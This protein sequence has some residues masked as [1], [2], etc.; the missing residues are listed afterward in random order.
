MLRVENSGMT[1][2]TERARREDVMVVVCGRPRGGGTQL[3]RGWNSA[4]LGSSAFVL[5][6]C[7]IFA[8]TVSLIALEGLMLRS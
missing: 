4:R 7:C 1:P 3:V 5:Y 8:A 6:I 2:V